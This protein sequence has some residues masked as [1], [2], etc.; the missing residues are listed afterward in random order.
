MAVSN[1]FIPLNFE[2]ILEKS[3][4][5]LEGKISMIGDKQYLEDAPYL[6]AL[7]KINYGLEEQEDGSMKRIRHYYVPE[8]NPISA[9]FFLA[10]LQHVG[11]DCLVH[12]PVE[13]SQKLLNRPRNEK[14]ALLFAVGHA[15]EGYKAPEL[16]RKAFSEII[17]GDSPFSPDS[18]PAPSIAIRPEIDD[19]SQLSV[20]ESYYKMIKRRRNVRHF[21]REDV[22][23]NLLYQAIRAAAT[24]PSGGNLQPYRFAIVSDDESKQK[25]R[26]LAEIEEKKLYEDR[27]SDEWRDALAPLGTDASKPHLT[28][29]PHLIIVFKVNDGLDNAQV[30]DQSL[31]HKKNNFALEAGSMAVGI[32][33]GALHRAGVCTLTHTPSP[34]TFVRDYLERPLNEVPFLVLPVGYPA[35][36]CE[37]PNITKKPLSEILVKY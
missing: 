31:L 37:V 20:A 21:S 34:M 22:D 29:A 13:A 32:L 2:R 23:I 16:I 18:Y 15:K 35:E 12:A 8:S 33:M 1:G 30:L 7:F 36:N 6:V 24:T 19:Q 28:D 17:I 4:H 11:L 9:G 14:P 27:I 5:T 3:D 26:E 10:A 25:I